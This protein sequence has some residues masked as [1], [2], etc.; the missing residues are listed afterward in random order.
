VQVEYEFL[1]ELDEVS[2]MEWIRNVF[3]PERG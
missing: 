1:A 3:E 2:G